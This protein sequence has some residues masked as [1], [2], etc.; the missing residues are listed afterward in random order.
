MCVE[1]LS[2]GC[3]WLGALP[4]TTRPSSNNEKPKK[5]VNM[6]PPPPLGLVS[7]QLA[8]PGTRV[9]AAQIAAV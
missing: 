3:L 4:N 6:F 1:V 8:E 2:N 5:A 7:D 9:N